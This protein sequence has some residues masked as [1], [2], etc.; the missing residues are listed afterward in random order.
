MVV[1]EGMSWGP[2]DIEKEQS[3][4]AVAEEAQYMP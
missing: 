1:M 3:N 2:D 4:P